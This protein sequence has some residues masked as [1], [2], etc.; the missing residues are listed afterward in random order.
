VKN[1]EIFDRLFE[2][3]DHHS[4]STLMIELLSTK[5]GTSKSYV[6]G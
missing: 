5:V 3:L 6:P 4:L 2:L 1:G